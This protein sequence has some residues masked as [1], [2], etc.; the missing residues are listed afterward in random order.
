[1]ENFPTKRYHSFIRI[2]YDVVLIFSSILLLFTFCSNE[3]SQGIYCPIFGEASNQLLKINA[4]E[5]KMMKRTS[6]D[7]VFPQ[8][9][10][11]AVDIARKWT[12]ALLSP[13]Y[14]TP[15]SVLYIP[16]KGDGRQ[17]C[18]IVRCNYS[19]LNSLKTTKR[20]SRAVMSWGMDFNSTWFA[21]YTRR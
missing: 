8:E 5:R 14:N 16:F 4:A 15:L 13:Q 2:I 6:T 12:E 7:T 3:S 20:R 18:D 21:Y 10:S 19:V 1:M 11:D 17:T 9:Q